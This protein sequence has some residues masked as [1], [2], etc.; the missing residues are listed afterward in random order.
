MCHLYFLIKFYF[1]VGVFFKDDDNLYYSW[2]ILAC[3]IFVPV[4]L[5]WWSNMRYIDVE[6]WCCNQKSSICINQKNQWTCKKCDQFN[7]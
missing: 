5:Y 2:G 4:V 7:G 1:Q 6:C 3:V